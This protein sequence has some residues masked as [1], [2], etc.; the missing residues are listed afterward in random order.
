M[1]NPVPVQPEEAVPQPVKKKKYFGLSIFAGF[2]YGIPTLL[3]GFLVSVFL[4]FFALWFIDENFPNLKVLENFDT[5]MKLLLAVAVLIGLILAI[6]AGLLSSR[7]VYRR[8]NEAGTPRGVAYSLLSC[9]GIGVIGLVVFPVLC[10]LS[11]FLAFAVAETFKLDFPIPGGT[12]SGFSIF[13][14]I[15]I[16][17]IALLLAYLTAMFLGGVAFRWFTKKR[18]G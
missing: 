10:Y 17:S 6:L 9:S 11:L 14:I 1:E 13:L 15:C 8:S 2:L 16:P 18:N 5:F 3:V 7:M 12:E 4:I